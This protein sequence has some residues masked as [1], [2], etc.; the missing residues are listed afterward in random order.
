MNF[1]TPA[2]IQLPD[3]RH[4]TWDG[5]ELLVECL[6]C[7]ALIHYIVPSIADVRTIEEWWLCGKCTTSGVRA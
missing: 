1:F 4:L 5:N 6:T 7:D 3:S 2:E